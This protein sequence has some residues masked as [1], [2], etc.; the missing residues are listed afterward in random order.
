MKC[1]MKIQAVHEG[2]P[3][4]VDV[5]VEFDKG[6]YIEVLKQMPTLMA[7]VKELLIVKKMKKDK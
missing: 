1:N 5:E 3:A 6:E 2:E 4:T 7:R